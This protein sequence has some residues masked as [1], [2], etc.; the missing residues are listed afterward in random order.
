MRHPSPGSKGD[1]VGEVWRGKDWLVM[2]GR[3]GE[4]RTNRSDCDRVV[5]IA[6]HDQLT[7]FDAVKHSDP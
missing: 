1:S 4:Q 7:A 3:A 6:N 2:L 5:Q